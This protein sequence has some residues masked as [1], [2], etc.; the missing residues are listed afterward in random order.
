MA[1]SKLQFTSITRDEL[2]ERIKENNS[3]RRFNAFMVMLFILIGA[4]IFGL[5]LTSNSTKE[6]FNGYGFAS[7]VWI[8]IIVL[9]VGK[10]VVTWV[11]SIV[12]AQILPNLIHEE[13]PLP[14]LTEPVELGDSPTEPQ[15][16]FLT[17]LEVPRKA[18][19]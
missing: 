15:E 9:M 14:P 2:L 10:L 8:G 1:M 17:F 5:G 19:T 12:Y 7:M 16:P 3:E 4:V 11:Q 13:T 18:R 6:S